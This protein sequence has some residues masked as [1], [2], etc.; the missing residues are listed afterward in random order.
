[1]AQV[2]AESGL[3]YV[4]LRLSR[5]EF[6]GNTP[7]DQVLKEVYED[8]VKQLAPNAPDFNGHWWIDCPGASRSLQRR[9]LAN[10]GNPP[11]LN[12]KGTTFDRR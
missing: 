7:K 11:V 12:N 2:S 1:M 6:P 9:S 3:D 4:R 5:V 8:L 10:S